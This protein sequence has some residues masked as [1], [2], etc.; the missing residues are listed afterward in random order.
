MC[1]KTDH[2]H[3]FI[4][5]FQQFAGCCKA[6]QVCNAVHMPRRMPLIPIILLWFDGRPSKLATRKSSLVPQC[7]GTARSRRPWGGGGEHFIRQRI[8]TY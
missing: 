6:V 7:A 2:F 1:G 5:Q 4:T 8:N 3:I